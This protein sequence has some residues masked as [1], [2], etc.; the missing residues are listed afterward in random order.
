VSTTKKIIAF[1]LCSWCIQSLYAQ[2]FSH[3]TKIKNRL[4]LGPVASYYQNHPEHT[5]NTAAQAGF[6]ASYKCEFL[7]DRKT[8]L[9]IGLD[10]L[11]QGLTFSGYY[12]A[13]GSTYLFDRTFAYT[14]D[15]RFQE[16]ELPII[17]KQAL[18]VEKDHFYTPYVLGGVGFRY[19]FSSYYVITNDSTGNEMYDGKGN[20]SF[21]HQVATQIVNSVFKNSQQTIT[22]GFNAFFQ[23]GLGDQYN[24]R[25]SG[26]NMFF[27]ITYKY[28]ISRL[29]YQ[30]YQNSNDLNIKDANLTFSIGLRF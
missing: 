23:I 2:D 1:I 24:F 28:G 30:G 18:N 5:A 10:Y 22:K 7:L 13:P 8:S 25:G 16:M 17:V 15:I 11:S 27:E 20:L 3:R 12:S 26:K 14:H 21:E 29:H 19:I 9:M 4:S 6:S